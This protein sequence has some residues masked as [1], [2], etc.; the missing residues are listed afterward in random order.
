MV[1]VARVAVAAPEEKTVVSTQDHPEKAPGSRTG[2]VTIGRNEGERLRRCLASMADAGG[3]IVY[4]DSGSTDG[5]VPWARAAGAEVVELDLSVP[6]TAARARNAGFERLIQLEPGTEYV[7]FADGDC[8][9]LPG[10]I[11]RAE[12]ELDADPK[13]AAVCGRR[14]ERHPEASV[15][16]RLCDIEWNTPPGPTKACGG[17]VLMRVSAL[18]ESGGFNPDLIAGEE[19]ELCVRLRRHGWTIL[20][21]DADMTLHDAS[22]TRFGQWWRRNIRAGHAYA[23][24]AALHGGPPERHWVKEVRSNWFWGA[25]LPVLA[26]GAAWPTRGLSLILVAG[27][28]LQ[29]WRIS[30]SMRARG[31]AARDARTHAFYT[32]LGKVPQ[33]LGQVKYRW[34]R[35]RGKRSRLIEYKSGPSTTAGIP[36]AAR[37]EAPKS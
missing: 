10:W 34:G 36:E 30:R 2:V 23:E 35:L 37:N 14:R 7:Q 25:A 5:S 15:Y 4:V 12:R 19:P 20:R 13:V 26:L 8:E 3:R 33:M 31:F 6:F 9:M 1:E 27:Y 32:V 29:A 11:R 24:G 17:D 28:L 21:I 22:M 16:N 18:R